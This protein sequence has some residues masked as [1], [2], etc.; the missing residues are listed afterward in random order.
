MTAPQTPTVGP[1]LYSTVERRR[2]LR[3]MLPRMKPYWQYAKTF[4]VSVRTIERDVAAIR[5]EVRAEVATRTLM[6]VVG[7]YLE[8]GRQLVKEAWATHDKKDQDDG[9]KLGALHFIH[10]QQTESLR[11]LQSCGYVP[12][13]PDRAIVANVTIDR[14]QS[15]DEKT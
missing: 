15:L 8:T 12:K 6:H 7:D 10:K 9:I 13:A 11:A 3:E 1:R 2:L 4:N 5:R 14:I